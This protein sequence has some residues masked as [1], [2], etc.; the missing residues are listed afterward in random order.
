M[1]PT[2]LNQTEIKEAK[3]EDVRRDFLRPV[4]YPW[5]AIKDYGPPCVI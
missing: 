1:N 4:V 5:E 2:H 3:L